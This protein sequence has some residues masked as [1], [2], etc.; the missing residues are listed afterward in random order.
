MSLRSMRRGAL[1]LL[2]GYGEVSTPTILDIHRGEQ[3]L[4]SKKTVGKGDEQTR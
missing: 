2:C 4:K 1:A 3:T